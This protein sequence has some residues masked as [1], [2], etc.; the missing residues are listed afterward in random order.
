MHTP[1]GAVARSRACPLRACR[2]LQVWVAFVLTLVLSGLVVWALD[3][4]AR[5]DEGHDADDQDEFSELGVRWG[6]AWVV[7]RVLDARVLLRRHEAKPRAAARHQLSAQLPAI[8][9]CRGAWSQ[10][11]ASQ[12]G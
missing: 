1:T 3:Y 8:L 6:L 10:W 11:R 9:A 7:M 12:W 2:L 4:W 5:V